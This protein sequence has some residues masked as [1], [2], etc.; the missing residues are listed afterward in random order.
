MRTRWDLILARLQGAY[1]TIGGVWPLLSMVAFED[2]TGNKT[3]EWLVRTV[4]GILLFLGAL[5]LY[6]SFVRNRIDRELRLIALGISSVLA[7][8]ALVSSLGGWVSWVYFIDGLVHLSFALGWMALA[9]R[10]RA[11]RVS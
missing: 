8:V 2:V 6:D 3:D 9:L 1:D 10:R 11:R 4:A 7:I 5:L